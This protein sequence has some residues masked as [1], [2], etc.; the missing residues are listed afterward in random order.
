M[1]RVPTFGAG[2][3]H[4]NVAHTQFLS[5]AQCSTCMDRVVGLWF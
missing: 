4:K 1:V 3:L 2:D 5:Q